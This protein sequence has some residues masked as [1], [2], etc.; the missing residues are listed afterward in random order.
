MII[1]PSTLTNGLRVV[2]S[3]KINIPGSTLR[4]SGT[5]NVNTTNKLVDT[6]RPLQINPTRGS[7]V[8]SLE[9]AP[10]QGQ[11]ADQGVQ[12]GDVVYNTT[13][14]TVGLVK[15]VDSAT[16]LSIMDAD[17]ADLD[18]FPDGNETYSI[19]QANGLYATPIGTYG[20][21]LVAGVTLSNLSANTSAGFNNAVD[22]AIVPSGGTYIDA[23]TPGRGATFTATTVGGEVTNVK[24]VAVSTYSLTDLA[25]LTI[26]FNTAAIETA[27][28]GGGT[29]AVTVTIGNVAS[30][31]EAEDLQSNSV[32]QPKA[33]QIYNGDTS[34]IDVAVITAGGDDILIKD[35]AIGTL[36]PLAVTR[37]KSTGTTAS[38]IIYAYS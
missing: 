10:S 16:T 33:F 12:V 5:A 18:L 31:D 30:G 15:A 6:T 14:W 38:K 23:M 8:Q 13:D 1:N 9:A 34:V 37:V 36:S 35:L 7:F 26:V 25:G 2:P 20:F 32:G 22:Q 4:F 3:D 24:V 17:G 21:R 29:G 28:G 27:F 11:V 19:Y